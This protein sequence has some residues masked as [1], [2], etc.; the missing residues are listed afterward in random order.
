MT[1]NLSDDLTEL[2]FNTFQGWVT[3]LFVQRFFNPTV[4]RIHTWAQLVRCLF[5]GPIGV[6]H[7]LIIASIF[8]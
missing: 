1:A 5:S 4:D 6:D 8:K 7:F 3:D 2:F